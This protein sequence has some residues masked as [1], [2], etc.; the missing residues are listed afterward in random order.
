MSLIKNTKPKDT[1]L[2]RNEPITYLY[3]PTATLT[4]TTHKEYY[5]LH[6]ETNVTNRRSINTKTKQSK[7]SQKTIKDI[8]EQTLSSKN[9]YLTT[10]QHTD[11][12][13]KYCTKHN[14]SEHS[15]TKT[16]YS[17]TM[18]IE[19]IEPN[20]HKDRTTLNHI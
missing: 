9:N 6:N 18:E 8:Y 1:L 16:P 19:Q 3:P 2:T 10:L 15:N 13:K 12:I 4:N 7:H 5:F 11:H 14:V 17:T 20:K